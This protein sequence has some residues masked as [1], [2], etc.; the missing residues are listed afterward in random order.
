MI[1][2]EVTDMIAA[3]VTAKI[4]ALANNVIRIYSQELRGDKCLTVG[5]SGGRSLA[6]GVPFRQFDVSIGTA[7]LKTAE[8]SFALLDEWTQ[9]IRECTSAL[10]ALAGPVTGSG[11][12]IDT[13]DALFPASGMPDEAG[14]DESDK[15]IM[16]RIPF[17]LFL[18]VKP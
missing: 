18:S 10:A 11:T 15:Y 4:P 13:I 7:I 14:V 2:D 17:T 3:V 5:V 1:E 9:T 12:E 8:N 6:P 16:H